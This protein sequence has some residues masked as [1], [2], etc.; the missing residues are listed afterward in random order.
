MGTLI[1]I[2]ILIRKTTERKRKQSDFNESRG[3]RC[4]E[5]WASLHSYQLNV[6]RKTKASDMECGCVTHTTNENKK[7]QVDAFRYQLSFCAKV[8]LTHK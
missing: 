2:Y 1:V 8:N 5:R 3:E 6:E 4:I 7:G